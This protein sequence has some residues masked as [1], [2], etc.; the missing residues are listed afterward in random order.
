MVDLDAAPVADEAHDRHGIGGGPLEKV[1]RCG[2]IEPADEISLDD[3]EAAA[4][5]EAEALQ[6]REEFVDVAHRLK[7]RAK[8]FDI[9][10]TAGSLLVRNGRFDPGEFKRGIGET[11]PDRIESRDIGS[12]LQVDLDDGIARLV[13]DLEAAP[14][15][16]LIRDL[17]GE[18]RAPMLEEQPQVDGIVEN[19]PGLARDRDLAE[20]ADLLVDGRLVPGERHHLA[21]IRKRLK[22]AGHICAEP[23]DLGAVMGGKQF[24]LG[25]PELLRQI[26]AALAVRVEGFRRLDSCDVR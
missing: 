12:G 11:I 21:Q 18:G 4:P 16:L 19:E 9:D 25:D 6:K 24:G 3:I 15:S 17:D 8:A 10:V 23:H 7:G 5:A 22:Q 20:R 2:K 26:A 13:E 14:R 1:A